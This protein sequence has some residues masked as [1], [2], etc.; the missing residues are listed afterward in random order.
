MKESTRKA[1]TI[2][3]AL[4]FMV[5]T[6][7]AQDSKCPLT[8]YWYNLSIGGD[9]GEASITLIADK[10]VGQNP[11]MNK[12]PSNGY[13]NL[14][15]VYFEKEKIYNLIYSKTISENTYEFIVQYYVGKQLKSGQLQLKRAGTKLSVIGI[16]PTTKKQPIHGKLFER[17]PGQ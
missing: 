15:D 11:H 10:K 8:G 14:A 16:D 2:T 17:S 6:I 7:S 1:I 13:I 4:F 3:I 5:I 9:W 12:I